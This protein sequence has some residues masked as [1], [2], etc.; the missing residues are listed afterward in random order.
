MADHFL[1]KSQISLQHCL[2]LGDG[3]ALE[4]YSALQ[5]LL[6]ERVSPSAA[7]LFAEPLIS[8]GNDVAPAS[9]SWYTNFAGEGR[10]LSELDDAAQARVASILSRDLR[11]MRDLLN[12]PEDGPLLAAA[13]HLGGAAKGD[14]W[15]VDGQPVILNWGMLPY[16]VSLDQDSRSEHF[17]ATLG[18]FLPLSAA[19]PLTDAERRARIALLA[20]TATQRSELVDSTAAVVPE[21]GNGAAIAP[22]SGTVIGATVPP[23]VQERSDDRAIPLIAWLPLVILLVLAGLILIWLLLPGTRIF[24][25]HDARQ[26]IETE[27]AAA[28]AQSV[29]EGLRERLAE[30][31]LAK[32]GA[33]CRADGELILPDGMTVDGM[34][35]PATGAAPVAAGSAAPAS[36]APVLPPDPSR[37]QIP[38]SGAIGGT[39]DGDISLLEL[40][41]ARTVMVIAEG[42][43]NTGTG[44]GFF[45]A[46]DLVITNHHVVAE[47]GAAGLFVTNRALGTLHPAE[48]LKAAGPFE[49]VGADFALLRVNGANS[50]FYPLLASQESLKLQ[51]VVAAGYPGDVLETDN[52][53]QQLL[54]GNVEAVPDLTVTDGTVNTQQ[55][56]GT[57]HAVVH[58]APIS[59]GNSG[60]PLI[61]LCGRVIGVN[62]FVRQGDLRNLNFALATSD[63][64]AFLQGTAATPLVETNACAPRLTTTTP[65]PAISAEVPASLD[66]LDEATPEA[67]EAAP[68][69][70][71]FGVV[72]AAGTE[73]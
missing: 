40:I 71:N 32:E 70:P 68:A 44:T 57:A 19:P 37:V 36:A 41:E 73:N 25:A 66:A 56:L 48:L 3:L 7:A 51:G 16:G 47:A 65:P 22:G 23:V 33:M 59:Q 11:A 5:A 1:T 55:S 26:A 72:S 46:P 9:I 54:N 60:G 12:D 52:A 2:K 58:S 67:A 62:T 61:D 35:P 29:N 14:I 45:I 21:A 43:D 20:S 10:P 34:L 18:R 53:F 50:P 49:Q 17:A 39:G 4:R 15:V 8:R 63:L 27:S 42:S 30:L 38:D 69:I 64:I 24:P 28:L 13:M 31:R 6:R